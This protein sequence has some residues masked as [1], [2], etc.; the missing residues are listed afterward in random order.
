MLD[1]WAFV[2][3]RNS[4]EDINVNSEVTFPSKLLEYIAYGKPIIST[5]VL[6]LTS[7]F[8]DLLMFYN[9]DDIL[10]LTKV[11]REIE[12]YSV[13]DLV[14]IKKKAKEFCL[15]NSWDAQ[16]RGFLNNINT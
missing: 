7:E 10:A 3:P 5:P 1:A 15:V 11:L 4:I 16:T 6:S 9:Q 13:H 12:S 14:V 2:N 8:K